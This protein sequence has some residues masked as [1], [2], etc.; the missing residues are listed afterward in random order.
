MSTMIEPQTVEGGVGAECAARQV[1]AHHE[2]LKS[3]AGGVSACP[4]HGKYEFCPAMD[5]EGK[6]A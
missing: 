1:L 5:R 4:L 3:C 6:A 2:L